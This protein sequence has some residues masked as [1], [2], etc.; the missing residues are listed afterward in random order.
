VTRLRDV[1][2]KLAP[3]EASSLDRVVKDFRPR[4]LNKGEHLLRAGDRATLLAFIERGLVR[5]YYVGPDGDEHVRS[6]CFEG[7]FTGSLYD[8]LS[9]APALVNIEALE[10][11]QLWV[12]D[13]AA[14]QKRCDREPAWHVAGRR[15]AEWLYC[16]KAV[17]EHQMLA[18]TA[19]E[20]WE[21]LLAEAPQL[22][23]RVAA[24]HLASY[25]GMTP[26]H[27]SRVRAARAPGS[28]S[29]TAR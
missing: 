24:R 10:P 3:V 29:R 18:L 27:L 14:F 11:T 16:R 4:T 25:L 7:M 15:H 19:R 2:A 9:Q 12:S 8:L 1:L 26:E 21:A 5:E 13:W 17:R 20:R 28:R 22:P 6:F 23:D